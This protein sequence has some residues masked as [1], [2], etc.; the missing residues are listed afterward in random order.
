M[1]IESI[2]IEEFADGEHRG[3]TVRN[4]RSD[5][6]LFRGGSRTGKT[7]TFNAVLSVDHIGFE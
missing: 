2:D 5:S 1:K 4:I 6:L 3:K 7:L